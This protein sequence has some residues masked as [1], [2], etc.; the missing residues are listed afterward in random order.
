MYN[1]ILS[2]L[3]QI[4][5]QQQT[6]LESVE[7]VCGPCHKVNVRKSIDFDWVDSNILKAEKLLSEVTMRK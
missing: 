4:C 2:E 5:K 7:Q 6:I 1:N 3:V